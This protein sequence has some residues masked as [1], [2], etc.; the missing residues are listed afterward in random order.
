[1]INSDRK[2]ASVIRHRVRSTAMILT[3]QILMVFYI[4]L[5]LVDTPPSYEA[6]TEDIWQIASL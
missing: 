4:F 2:E 5:T 3:M 1:M 6:E